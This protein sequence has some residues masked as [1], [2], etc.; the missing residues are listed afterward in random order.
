[1]VCVLRLQPRSWHWSKLKPLQLGQCS[2]ELKLPVLDEQ[3][4]PSDFD[5]GPAKELDKAGAIADTTQIKHV[6]LSFKPLSS[7]K[8]LGFLGNLIR[9]YR[10]KSM[11]YFTESR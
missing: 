8:L 1:M 6:Q 7:T 5:L 4:M 10:I 11:Y 9:T 3:G 2:F